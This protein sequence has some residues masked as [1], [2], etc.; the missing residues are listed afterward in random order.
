MRMSVMM[1]P[2]GAG[3]LNILSLEIYSRR[4]Y[5]A[6]ELHW[7]HEHP[8]RGLAGPGGAGR[9]RRGA[10]RAQ[11]APDAPAVV[12]HRDPDV[13]RARFRCGTR[14]GGVRGLGEDRLQLLPDQG[15]TR[16]G[17]P[18]GHDG[19]AAD[20]PGRARG[21]AGAGGAADPG[22]RT[23]SHDRVAHRPGRPGRGGSGDPAVRRPDPRHAVVARLS[24]R[25]DGPVRVGGRREPGRPG[26]D[27]GRRSGTP[28]R[29][30]GHPG[31][32]AR[33]GREPAEAPGE[34]A[35][36]GARAGHGRP[37]PGRA[38]DRERAGFVRGPWLGRVRA[39]MR[40]LAVTPVRPRVM[41]RGSDL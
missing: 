32:V 39:S 9:T 8:D 24:E 21:P 18:G 10:A 27:G 4:T 13:R 22:P 20:R 14:R 2:V 41:R 29:G 38:A 26:R 40:A 17:P 25:H 16:P 5:I 19:L 15:I 1:L 30:A 3:L 6:T 31:A 34:R 36:T 7:D 23:E 28:D 35:R 37:P 33:P 11:E 12:R